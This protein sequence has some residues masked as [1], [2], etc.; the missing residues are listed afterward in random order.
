M[1]PVDCNHNI[2]A[3]T[4]ILGVI[5][6][7]YII[8]FMGILATNSYNTYQMYYNYANF[9]IDFNMVTMLLFCFCFVFNFGGG[10][11]NNWVVTICNYI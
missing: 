10:I 3:Y 2:T 4:C 11:Q 8:L 5:Y 1:S 9:T 6:T 7:E